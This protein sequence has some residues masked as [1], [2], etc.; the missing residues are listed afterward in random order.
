M[1]RCIHGDAC[2]HPDGPEL[3]V[4]AFAEKG[5]RC[6]ACYRKRR[7]KKKRTPEESAARLGQALAGM[8]R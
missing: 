3:P 8:K 2:L 5:E 4:E 1:R 7:R 6:E